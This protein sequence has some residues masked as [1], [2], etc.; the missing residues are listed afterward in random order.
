MSPDVR[1]DPV[2]WRQADIESFRHEAHRFVDW[3]AD[4]LENSEQYP[5]LSRAAPGDIRALLE[6]SA[7]IDPSGVTGLIEEV[8]RVVLPGLTHWNSPEFMAYFGTTA[9]PP[10]IIAELLAATLNQNALNWQ[11][12]PAL[13]EVEAA[14]LD[15]LRQMLGLPEGLFGIVYDTASISTLCAVAAARDRA[16]P[17]TGRR[18][19]AG[20]PRMRIYASEE[21]HSV[22]DKAAMILGI[23]RQNI[24]KIPVDHE[25][26]M[27]PHAL[28]EAIQSD[29]RAGLTPLCVVA[30]VGT[31]S[32]TSI[33]PVRQVA[34][35]TAKYNIWLHIDAAY[36]GSAA[37]LP[38]MQWILDGAEMADSICVNPHK[39]LFVPMDLSAFYTRHPEALRRSFSYVR[40]YLETTHDDVVE[41]L[42]DYGPQLGRR[43]RGLKL[44]FVIRAYG[45]S[46]MQ[47]ILRRHIELA[48]GFERWIDAHGDFELMAPR[49]FS[50]VC[51]RSRPDGASTDDLNALNARLLHAVNGSGD[52][53]ISQTVVAGQFILRLA[54]GNMWTEQ[55]HVE[56]VQELLVECLPTVLRAETT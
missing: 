16:D 14:V 1:R 29:L 56:R 28:D 50:T 5:V 33:D 20:G 49:H 40:P 45:V 35:I 46:G 12:S 23:G 34:E 32:T 2:A 36:G 38:E 7:S 11:A 24:R 18:G 25:F 47:S 26:R 8:E 10:G 41:N 42:S 19:I 3:A 52:A 39:W 17:E 31:T 44:W 54:I 48:A 4:Y 9:S 43:F 21:A 22:V 30:T 6:S 51:F 53:F 55:S 37:I 13:N 15:W 27:L